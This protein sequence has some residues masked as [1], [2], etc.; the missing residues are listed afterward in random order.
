MNPKLSSVIPQ[1]TIMHSNIRVWPQAEDFK[2]YYELQNNFWRTLRK[3]GSLSQGRVQKSECWI[4]HYTENSELK[5]DIQTLS[6]TGVSNLSKLFSQD[7][8]QNVFHQM[9]LVLN[10]II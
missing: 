3:P 5:Y 8:W 4:K 6:V 2:F 7:D 10:K 1:N 9:N